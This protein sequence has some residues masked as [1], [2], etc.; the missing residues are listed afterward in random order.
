MEN[1]QQYLSCHEEIL[2]LVRE[3]RGAA[4]SSNW[5]RLTALQAPYIEQVD[6]LKCA[7]YSQEL[8]HSERQYRY[9]LLK[10]I[11]SEDAAVR[12]LVMPAFARVS[13]LLSSGRRR[14]DL[15]HAYSMAD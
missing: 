4:Q 5:D 14:R 8:S 1:T 9:E 6:R 15:S 2:R 3:M 12:N 10:A 13:E 7:S 11:L